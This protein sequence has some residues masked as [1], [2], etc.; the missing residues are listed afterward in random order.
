M[1]VL[2]QAVDT[3]NNNNNNIYSNN[4]NKNHIMINVVRRKNVHFEPFLFC[5][6]QKDA[7]YGSLTRDILDRVEEIVQRELPRQV[8]QYVYFAVRGT[9]QPAPTEE[10]TNE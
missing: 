6:H 4:N 7:D 5:N 1:E 9:A 10:R 2:Q 3:H 8:S